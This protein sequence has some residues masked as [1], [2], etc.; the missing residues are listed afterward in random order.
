LAYYVIKSNER[1]NFLKQF[2]LT[3]LKVKN[4]MA[5]NILTDI[6]KVLRGKNGNLFLIA[7]AVVGLFFFIKVLGPLIWLAIVGG[8]IFLAF[9]FMQNRD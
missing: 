8:I 4:I 6:V 9:R 3:I 1:L 5:N 2:G 7:M